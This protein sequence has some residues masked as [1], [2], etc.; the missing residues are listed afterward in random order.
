MSVFTQPS[1]IKRAYVNIIR[2]S[3][4][5]GLAEGRDNGDAGKPFVPYMPDFLSEPTCVT[6]DVVPGFH[7]WR[8]PG[9]P[10]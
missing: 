6:G 8:R 7:E 3:Q 5:I 2:L 1:L 10:D 9:V 4:D